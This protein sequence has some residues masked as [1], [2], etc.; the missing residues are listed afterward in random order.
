MF[1]PCCPY[2]DGGIILCFF[3]KS[4]KKRAKITKKSKKMEI[5]YKNAKKVF[6]KMKKRIY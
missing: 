5:F 1:S 3:Y 6:T 2:N 4:S